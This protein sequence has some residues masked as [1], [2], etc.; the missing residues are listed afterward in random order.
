MFSPNWIN[1]KC[2]PRTRIL[3]YLR[4]HLGS[5]PPHP[6]RHP[7]APLNTQRLSIV[8]FAL[9]SQSIRSTWSPESEH[10]KVLLLGRVLPRQLQLW[11]GKI[12]SAS[13]K[14]HLS[15]DSWR[16]QVKPPLP[17]PKIIR[18]LGLAPRAIPILEDR[19]RCRG[20]KEAK[21]TSLKVRYV[22]LLLLLS[23]WLL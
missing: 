6:H 16:C 3:S 5:P 11:C 14:T 10:A 21:D 2:W 23:W 18:W 1:W 20:K 12:T 7:P 4:K 22:S 19:R 15:T 9:S 8:S 17:V 13:N